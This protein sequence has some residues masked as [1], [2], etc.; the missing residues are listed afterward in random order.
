MK[1]SQSGLDEFVFWGFDDLKKRGIVGSRYDL[2]HK[3]KE[4]GFPRSI[5]LNQGRTSRAVFRAVDV[6]AWIEG[7]IG[8]NEAAE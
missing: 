8:A 1:K 4:L 5:H 7:R 2:C 3:Q 6:V